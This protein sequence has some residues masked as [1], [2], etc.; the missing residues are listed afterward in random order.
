MKLAFLKGVDPASRCRVVYV[1]DQYGTD[2]GLSLYSI[3]GCGFT[4]G[5]G[6]AI[7]AAPT[8]AINSST[9]AT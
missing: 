3:R 2:E 5:F 1:G 7:A 8:S 4:G 9:P 6:V